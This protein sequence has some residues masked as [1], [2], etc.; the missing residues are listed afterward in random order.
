MLRE[1]GHRVEP[2]RA[3]R[4][5]RRARRRRCRGPCCA[6]RSSTLRS[7]SRAGTIGVRRP[8]HD[9]GVRP[10]RPLHH[11]QRLGELHHRPAA[12][13]SLERRA[14]R[15]GHLR[16]HLHQ[17]RLHPD[18]DVRPPGRSRPHPE[19]RPAGS[20]WTWS[21]GTVHWAGDPRPDLR[22][23]RP[24]HAARSENRREAGDNVT[25]SAS[26]RASSDRGGSR[27]A[28][29]RSSRADRFVLGAGSR[30]VRAGHPGSG[31][32]AFHTSD[33]VMR[34]DRLPA[35]MII[36]GGGYV[37]AEFAHIFSSFGT[38]VTVIN[39]SDRLLRTGGRRGRRR[40]SPSSWAA[41]S[42]L[43]LERELRAGRAGRRRHDHRAHRRCGRS[44]GT[45][46]PRRSCWSP[47]VVGPTPTRS[48]SSRPGSRSTT[49]ASSW[50]TSTRR[51]R[52][53]G[54]SPSAT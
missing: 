53:R 52:C 11:R 24:D 54:S 22:T 7:P 36:V 37:A 28:T 34:L 50:S 16:R 29:G 26:R 43:D 39:R 31:H 30:V 45:P 8:W 21:C 15:A 40:G 48:I 42:T 1:A 2:G 13:T 19:R 46:P 44:T 25:C 10:L 47:P 38:R 4:L 14:G 41:T 5:P 32:V 33:T 51:P 12:S 17:R 23:D 9:E 3:A 49:T 18:Q 27:S 6:T 35:S 20:A